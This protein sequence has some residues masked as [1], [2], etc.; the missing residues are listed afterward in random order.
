MFKFRSKLSIRALNNAKN[1][2]YKLKSWKRSAA[3]RTMSYT[4]EELLS[5][6]DDK[7]DIPEVQEVFDK[8]YSIL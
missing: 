5:L 3:I 6:H 8:P 2:G 4:R 7:L 1:D